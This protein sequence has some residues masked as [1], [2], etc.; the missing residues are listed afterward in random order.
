MAGEKPDPCKVDLSN[1]INISY[2]DLSEEQRQKFK[3]N[4]H[5]QNEEIRAKMLACY[6]KTRQG[7]I[8]KE[9][10]VMPGTQSATPPAPSTTTSTSLTTD[11][12]TPK[13]PLVHFLRQFVDK[14][15]KFEKSQ[16]LT[17]NLIF[18][19]HEMIEKGKSVDTSYSTKDI[20][21]SST[22]PTSNDNVQY[23]MPPNYFAGQSPPP[24]TVRPTA[25]EPVRPVASTGPTGSAVVG[26]TV[27]GG[28]DCPAK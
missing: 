23:G 19:M 4:L 9:K 2:E 15:D 20:A 12:S 5:R 26:R 3:A 21:Q 7:V 17:Q 28:D 25:A 16:T 22:A 6:R 1:T 18:E 13:D 11:V 27:P 8:E 10:F 24:G 14:F